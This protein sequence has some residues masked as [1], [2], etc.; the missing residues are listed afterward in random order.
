M[1]PAL[2][3]FPLFY[4]S[5]KRR[6][7]LTMALITLLTKEQGPPQ[8]THPKALW[9]MALQK[10]SQQPSRP[11]RRPPSRGSRLRK[12]QQGR[13]GSRV[14]AREATSLRLRA[15]QPVSTTVKDCQPVL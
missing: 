8:G 12:G 9:L 3:F 1:L 2:D 6:T 11:L 7:T 14:A 13:V 5:S 4:R 10:A 15:E